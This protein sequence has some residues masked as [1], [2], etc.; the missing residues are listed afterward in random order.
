MLVEKTYL[1]KSKKLM[2]EKRRTQKMGALQDE[3]VIETGN[4]VSELI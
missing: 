2:D 4:I 1:K 3:F